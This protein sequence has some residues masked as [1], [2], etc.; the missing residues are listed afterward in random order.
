MPA[1][2]P[3]WG[4]TWGR[5]PARRSGRRVWFA[6]YAAGVAEPAWSGYLALGG[7]W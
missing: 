4:T 2:E 7:H 3:V 6:W 1:E 5:C